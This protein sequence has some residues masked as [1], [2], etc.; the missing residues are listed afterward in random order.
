MTNNTTLLQ[1]ATNGKVILLENML[2][3]GADIN[4]RDSQGN[5]PLILAAQ[6]GRTDVV[7]IL[8]NKGC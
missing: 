3:I 4:A 6:N 5:T 8:L 1:A 2:A 7:Y